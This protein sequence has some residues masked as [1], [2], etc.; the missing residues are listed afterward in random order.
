VLESS[1]WHSW[2]R[3]PLEYFIP[4]N[5]Q[6]NKFIILLLTVLRKFK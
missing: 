6:T 4:L 3:F 1:F 5:S 2:L